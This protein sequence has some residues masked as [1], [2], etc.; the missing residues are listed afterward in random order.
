MHCQNKQD[1]IY[2]GELERTATSA[3][4]ACGGFAGLVDTIEEEDFQYGCGKQNCCAGAFV[5]YAC[6]NRLVASFE[7]PEME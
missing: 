1:P 3:I 2:I 4:C 6:G 5:C 7:A